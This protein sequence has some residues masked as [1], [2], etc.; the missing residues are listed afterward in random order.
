MALDLGGKNAIAIFLKKFITLV[1]S[2][3]NFNTL[4]IMRAVKGN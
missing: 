1:M 4:R 3:D 2:G